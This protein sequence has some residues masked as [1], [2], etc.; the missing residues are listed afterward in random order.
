MPDP[1]FDDPIFPIFTIFNFPN[2]CNSMALIKYRILRVIENYCSRNN[3]LTHLR[4][5]L[6]YLITEVLGVRAKPMKESL[7]T[8][9]NERASNSRLTQVQQSKRAYIMES[10][11]Q[12]ILKTERIAG[13][14]AQEFAACQLARILLPRSLSPPESWGYIGGTLII[15]KQ[16]GKPFCKSNRDHV[17]LATDFLSKLHSVDISDNVFQI[18]SEHGF[19]R[20]FR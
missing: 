3:L 16:A 10:D 7:L 9:L 2:G 17:S 19:N 12:L 1:N 5:A 8:L 6:R 4:T 14:A 20:F 13:M 11:N 15:E 18:L